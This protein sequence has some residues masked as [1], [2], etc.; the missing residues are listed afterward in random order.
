MTNV[1]VV[2]L[3]DGETFTDVSGCVILTVPYEQYV[4]VVESGGNAKDF[5]PS[6]VEE[7]K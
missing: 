4:S 7:I 3:N 1:R 6:H 5:S 2:V